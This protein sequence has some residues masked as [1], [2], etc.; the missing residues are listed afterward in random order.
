MSKTD[1]KFYDRADEH[2][3]LSNDQLNNATKGEVSASMMYG[4]SRFNAW[5]SATGWNSSTEMKNAK[6]ETIKYFTIEYEKMLR[7]NLTDYI[8]NFD[9]YMK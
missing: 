3:N 2:I 9:R 6:E 5:I 8:E 4:V 7:E 1:E